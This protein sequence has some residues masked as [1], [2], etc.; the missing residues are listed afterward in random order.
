M[1]SNIPSVE[2]AWHPTPSPIAK[3]HNGM[4][5]QTIYEYANILFRRVINIASLECKS[6]QSNKYWN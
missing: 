4:T 5:W 6:M 3:K 2:I 1:Y